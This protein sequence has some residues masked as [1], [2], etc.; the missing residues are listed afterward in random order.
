[1]AATDDSLALEGQYAK[2][3]REPL[4]WASAAAFAGVVVGLAGTFSWAASMVVWRGPLDDVLGAIWLLGL[5]GY[6]LAALSLLGV[7]ALAS[8]SLGRGSRALRIGTAL[9]LAWLPLELALELARRLYPLLWSLKGLTS[10]VWTV[11]SVATTLLGSAALLSLGLGA[12]FSGARRLGGVLLI[13]WVP[14]GSLFFGA[15]NA[16]TGTNE[17]SQQ[18]AVTTTLLFGAPLGVAEA[19]LFT[20]LGAMLLAG[21]RG[22]ALAHAE[23]ENRKKA[24][25]L[26]EVGLGKNEPSVV[27]EVVS[28]DFRDPRRG[29]SGKGGMGRIVADLW[30]SYPDLEVSVEG[31]EAEGDVVRTRLVLSGTDRS[32]GVMWYP[33]TGRR[34][35]FEAEFVDRFSGGLMVEHAGRADTEGLLRQLGHHRGG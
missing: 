17:I 35:S 20:L 24:L 12:F 30:A 14:A 27:E 5:P 28:E 4:F 26:Y 19:C 34:V 7:P 1:M 2:L 11:A 3:L 23:E 21:A 13:L 31:Q 10:P 16:L 22:R 32:S 9:L 8:L 6:V 29:V 25:R 18:L 15:H 33:P